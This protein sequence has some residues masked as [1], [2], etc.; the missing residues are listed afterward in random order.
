MLGRGRVKRNRVRS[1]EVSHAD[2]MLELRHRVSRCK[3]RGYEADRDVNAANNILLI[4]LTGT[5]GG[6]PNALGERGY[7]GFIVGLTAQ[8][9]SQ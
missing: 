7:T 2:K 3:N 5:T 6:R 8:N 4:G 1:E 9:N